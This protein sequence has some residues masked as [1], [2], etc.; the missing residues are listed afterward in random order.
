MVLHVHLAGL[1]ATALRHLNVS[2][3]KTCVF[4]S[5]TY[6]VTPYTA[7]TQ[8]TYSSVIIMLVP[9]CS[10]VT[11]LIVYQQLWCVMVS[12]IVQITKMSSVAI[13][14]SVQD[15][16]CVKKRRYVYMNTEFAMEKLT[17]CIQWM[18][19]SYAMSLRVMMD[20]NALVG[21]L[22]ALMLT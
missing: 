11:T 18:M 5:A 15:Y 10:N 2:R 19:N 12:V 16:W 9:A 21:V 6:M 4:M 1:D 13:I 7:P 3:M 8:T 14:C 20:A 22:F 17:A